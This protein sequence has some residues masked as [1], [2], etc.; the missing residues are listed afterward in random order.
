MPTTGTKRALAP[1][2]PSTPPASPLNPLKKARLT[3][4]STNEAL[5]ELNAAREEASLAHLSNLGLTPQLVE[6]APK[7]KGRYKLQWG[8]KARSFMMIGAVS[9]HDVMIKKEVSHSLNTSL[10]HVY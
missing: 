5:K 8:G 7:G 4:T 3:Y 2:A 1:M 10:S 9:A 6:V